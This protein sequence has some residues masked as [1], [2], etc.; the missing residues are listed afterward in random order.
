M[1]RKIL[2][3]L[4]GSAVASAVL[5]V[6]LTLAR[7]TGAHLVLLRVL[8]EK[9]DLPLH[10]INAQ[11]Y[12]SLERI[13][14]EMTAPGLS[15]RSVVRR[16]DPAE[17]I[18]AAVRDEQVDLIA[19]AT[20]GLASV[21]RLMVG[22]VSEQIVAH[23]PVPVLLVTPGGHAVRHIRSML[24]PVDGS[25]GAALALGAALPLARATGAQLT[26]LQVAPPVHDWEYRVAEG[27]ELGRDLSVGREY[28]EA[29]RARAEDY[30]N[31]MA[32]RLRAKGF[33]AS[34]LARVG[35]PATVID[36]SARERHVDLIVMSTHALTGPARALLGSVADK[37]V[38]ITDRPVLLVRQVHSPGHTAELRARETAI[39]SSGP[40]IGRV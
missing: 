31:R 24:V 9:D 15:I 7:A 23:S 28:E 22:S 27:G 10:D 35:A 39:A 11:V 33:Q 3:P 1:L 25:P 40:G 34:G 18:L 38:H 19:M 14:R 29:G 5:P 37:V 36:E 32:E 12:Q 4:D 26:L 16:G 30:V 21:D 8:P 2:I 17:Q 13:R 20:Y 6:A